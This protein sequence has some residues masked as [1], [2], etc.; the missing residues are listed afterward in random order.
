MSEYK[1]VNLDTLALEIIK[2]PLVYNINIALDFDIEHQIG[3]IVTE[4]EVSCW[5]ELRKI[6]MADTVLI[7][8]VYCGG[9]LGSA[10]LFDINTEHMSE[11]DIKEMQTDL[12]LN[13]RNYLDSC[14]DDLLAIPSEE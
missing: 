9:Q 1:I 3:D 11:R 7:A 14:G 8:C 4:N 12:V 5:Y 10:L 6:Y 2:S 13:L